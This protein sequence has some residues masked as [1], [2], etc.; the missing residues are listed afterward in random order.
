M[1]SIHLIKE[2]PHI[3][4]IKNKEIAESYRNHFKILWKYAKN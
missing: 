1:D 4:I 3:V 2:K